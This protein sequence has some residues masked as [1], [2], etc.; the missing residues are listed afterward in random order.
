VPGV[1]DEQ[2]VVGQ[3]AGELGAQALG[4]QRDLV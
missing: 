2:R 1:D 4:A 3:D